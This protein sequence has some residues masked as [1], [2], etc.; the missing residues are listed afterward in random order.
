MDTLKRTLLHGLA[1]Y[2]GNVENQLAC[3]CKALWDHQMSSAWMCLKD[4]LSCANALRFP[5]QVCHA[6]SKRTPLTFTN[7]FYQCIMLVESLVASSFFPGRELWELCYSQSGSLAVVQQH[8]ITGV[9]WELRHIWTVWAINSPGNNRSVVALSQ[10][11]ILF[12]RHFFSTF[13]SSPKQWVWALNLKQKDKVHMPA[14]ISRS[15]GFHVI[16]LYNWI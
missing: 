7:P 4:V 10:V 3:F 15:T 16:S 11:K 6:T 2:L 14:L 12:W 13:F 8:W 9:F 5:K 1:L